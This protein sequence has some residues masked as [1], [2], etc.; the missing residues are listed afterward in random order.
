M[1]F[2]YKESVIGFSLAVYLFETYLNWRQHGKLSEK[3]RP[4]AIKAYI[5]EEVFT[6]SRL[7]GIDKSYFRFITGAWSAL[8]TLV[9]LHFDLMP[10]LWTYAGRVLFRYTGLGAEYE[11]TQSIVFFA[12]F[13]IINLVIELPSSLYK[14]FVLEE[15]HGFNK[16]TL[17]IFVTDLI[18][19]TL[20]T[21]ALGSPIL[22]GFLYVVKW[23][24][25]NFAFYVWSFM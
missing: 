3:E 5:E 13:Y 14:D 2:P 12:L 21:L 17:N 20:L 15:K 11:I 16:S 7:Y 24:G 22:A 25:A 23:A 19:S 9:Y 18:K 8:Q 10:A 1:T 6:K 4:E